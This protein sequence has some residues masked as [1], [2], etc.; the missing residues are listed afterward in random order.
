MKITIYKQQRLL[1][2]FGQGDAPVF[3]APIALGPEPVGPKRQEGDGKTPE[4][5]YHICLTK[6][7]GRHGKS[8]GLSYPSIQDAD[9]ALLEGRIDSATH[10]AIHAA[11]QEGR[12][13]PWGS[14][15]GGEIYIH[16]GGAQSDWT[17]GC[18]ALEETDME[19]LFPLADQI[20]SVEILP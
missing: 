14:P 12:R 13:P 17:Q 11:Q 20:T 4:G 9:K 18:I 1:C 8:L 7:P 5:V 6:N 2:L 16:G 10:A 19:R 3:C 15:L